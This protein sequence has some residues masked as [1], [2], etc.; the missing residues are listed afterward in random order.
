[1]LNREGTPTI[2]GKSIAAPKL[3]AHTNLL[4]IE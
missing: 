1:L 3:V 2:T 4:S